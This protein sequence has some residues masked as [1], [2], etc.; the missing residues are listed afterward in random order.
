MFDMGFFPQIK[1]IIDQCP[2]NDERQTLLFTAT[3]QKKVQELADPLLNSN[4]SLVSI[5][6]LFAMSAC[7]DIKQHLFLTNE[8]DKRKLLEAILN[9]FEG[10]K[11]L[12]FTNTKLRTESLSDWAKDLNLSYC[13]YIHGDVSQDRRERVI[14]NFN[15]GICKVIFATDVASRG[16][17]MMFYYLLL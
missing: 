11:I 8:R 10:F 7:S 3:W 17:G 2:S 9:E 13:E 1:K 4:R 5:G 15:N 14:K 12:V 16:L 6:N